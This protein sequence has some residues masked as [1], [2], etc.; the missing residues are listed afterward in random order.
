M[1]FETGH[2]ITVAAIIS[3]PDNPPGDTSG[4]TSGLGWGIS[5]LGGLTFD[6]SL[7]VSAHQA[8]PRGLHFSRDGSRMYL[9]GNG[10]AFITTH[11]LD[12]PWDITTA[13]YAASTVFDWPLLGLWFAGDGVQLVLV[14]SDALVSVTLNT[15]WDLGGGYTVVSELAQSGWGLHGAAL[16]EAGD[17]IIMSK[18]V[19]KRYATLST[20]FDVSS[21]SDPIN[22]SF[23]KSRDRGIFANDAGDSLFLVDQRDD[24]YHYQ[25]NTPWVTTSAVLGKSYAL[26]GLSK[27]GFSTLT[28]KA[29]GITFSPTGARV[30]VTSSA[31][32]SVHQYST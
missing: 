2:P 25:I 8:D 30:Y 29:Q 1:L 15:P 9:C 23:G 32:Q 10:S 5:D 24:I 18:A 26:S 13:V 17:K 28:D 21:A 12:V 3:P 7:D 14:R 4:D 19:N 11:L 20:P 6:G 31:T 27:S 16:N 22:H